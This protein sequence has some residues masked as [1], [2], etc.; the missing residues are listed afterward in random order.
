MKPSKSRKDVYAGKPQKSKKL[1][2]APHPLKSSGAGR[3]EAIGI[4]KLAVPVLKNEIS[5]LQ[6]R[7]CRRHQ[8][9]RFWQ[10]YSF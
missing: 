9:G 3:P 4:V 8:K 5:L 1:S 7:V 2:P 6:K 10:G